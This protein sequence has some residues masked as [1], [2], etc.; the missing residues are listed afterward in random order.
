MQLSSSMENIFKHVTLLG[1]L[2]YF[3]SSWQHTCTFRSP[4]NLTAL[5]ISSMCSLSKGK[6]KWCEWEEPTV[7]PPMMR[8]RGGKRCGRET[9]LCELQSTM[10]AGSQGHVLKYCCFEEMLF[11][12][13]SNTS[14]L[15]LHPFF[16]EGIRPF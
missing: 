15:G 10:K 14:S 13:Q 4:P 2:K 6:Q 9:Q 12:G 1:K 7:L 16:I 3:S 5:S 11:Q 8:C